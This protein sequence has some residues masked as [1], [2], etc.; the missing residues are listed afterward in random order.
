MRLKY[1][2]YAAVLAGFTLGI[3]HAAKADDDDY[4]RG[5]I[6]FSIGIAP[7]AYYAPPPV[8]YR[9]APPPV[10]YAPQPTYYPRQSYYNNGYY[11]QDRHDDDDED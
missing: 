7:P 1:V 8:Y 6:G 5:G 4:G 11:H 9:P 3:G 2:V 10:Y